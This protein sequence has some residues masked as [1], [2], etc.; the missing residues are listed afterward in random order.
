M[1]RTT[2]L[3]SR[4]RLPGN[5]LVE[6]V[7]VDRSGRVPA[8]IAPCGPF[9]APEAAGVPLVAGGI[10]RRFA[11]FDRL[12]RAG[13]VTEVAAPAGSGKTLLLRSW[14]EQAGLGSCTAWV[15]VRREERDPQRFWVSVVEALRATGVVAGLIGPLTAAPELDGWAVVERLLDDLASLEQRV[16]LVIDD[17]HELRSTDALRQ[18][19]LLLMRAPHELRVVL[20]SRHDLSLGLHRLRLEGE[21]TEIRAADLRFGVEEAGA[22]LGAAG[23]A[24]PEPVLGRLVARTEGWAAGLRLAALSLAGHP[25]PEWFAEEFSG[26]ARTVADY[27]LAE[28]LDRQPE[29]VRR[30]LLRTSVLERVSGPLAD[31]LTGDAGGER[32]LQ[33]LE[34]ANAFVVSL[35]P[36][37]SWFR[38][39]QLFADLLQLELR[40]TAPMELPGLHAAAADWYVEHGYPV[41][42]IRHA[43]A[44]GEWDVA[45]RLLFDHWIELVLDGQAA[46]AHEL[47]TA[48]PAAH[49]AA[50]AELSALVASDEVIRGSLDE[51][52]RCLD[53]AAAGVASVSS[54]RRSRFEIRLGVLRL[55]HA[56]QRGDLP[57]VMEEVERLLAPAGEPDAARLGLDD[58]LRAFVLISLGIA[59]SWTHRIDEAERHLET[60]IALARRVE[61]PFLE[62]LG[63]AHSAFAACFRSFALA[64]QRSRQAIELARRHGW[65]E[66]PAV[67]PAY[68]ALGGTTL[69]QGRLEEAD[70]WLGLAKRT[71]QVEVEPASGRVLHHLCAL[72]EMARGRDKE[73]LDVFRA[74]GRLAELMGPMHAFA[75]SNRAGLLRTLVR[76]GE[77]DRVERAFLDMRDQERE[78]GPMR[79]ALA[80]LRLAQGDPQAATIALAPVVDDC[81]LVVDLPGWVVQ[82]LLLEAIARDALGDAGGSERALERALDL[83]E[84]DFVRLPF[85]LH[86]APGLLERH[87]RDCPVHAALIDETLSLMAGQ[88][89]PP[90]PPASE[91]LREPLSESETRVLRYL[92]T[93]LTAPEIAAELFLSVHTVKTHMRHV[94]AKLG[95]H[96]RAEAVERA[97]ALGLLAPSSRKRVG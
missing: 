92:P 90:A 19:E 23:V 84:P 74:G 63:L 9:A 8:A 3:T 69:W 86:P 11:L 34:R 38:Y 51:A 75:V 66:E 91:P 31:A 60:G 96:R 6:S 80:V 85:L 32:I 53:R 1:P 83:A 82:A 59:E 52:E 39:H 13:R 29:A 54:E 35:D 73:A 7:A 71:L 26:S 25:E 70:R 2:L 94:Y 49:L 44:A 95:A 27:L 18:L 40:R 22:L 50:D 42:A 81:S 57:A 21:L 68:L 4:T 20:A 67:A 5:R 87:A 62:V 45:A 97:R 55:W 65:S 58:Y 28:V 61:R 93:N 89:S 36:G 47:L 10:V 79:L 37:R 46:T 17:V 33:D 78:S 72:L 41:D 14:I 15:S 30:L 76:L 56:R 64:E 88:E 12:G 16:W 24:L 43:Q 48:F 77:I